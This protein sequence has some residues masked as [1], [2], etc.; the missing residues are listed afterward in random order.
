MIGRTTSKSGDPAL[1]K[2]SVRSD[3]NFYILHRHLAKLLPTEG[4]RFSAK[5]YLL[6]DK[7]VIFTRARRRIP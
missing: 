2:T 1:F 7:R 6:K 5:S 4:S 3:P